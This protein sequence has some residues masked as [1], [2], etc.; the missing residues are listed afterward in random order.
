MHKEF[1]GDRK[2]TRPTKTRRSRIITFQVQ[3]ERDGDLW[4]WLQSMK[5]GQPSK[6]IRTLLGVV[7]KAWLSSAPDARDT[8]ETFVGKKLKEKDETQ[9]PDN[10]KKDNMQK[11]DEQQKL[12]AS[13]ASALL[14][15]DKDFG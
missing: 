2:K 5:Y 9:R 13:M 12:S 11:P 1:S 15:M 3:E 10:H 6:T 4:I 7:A 8:M 14:E